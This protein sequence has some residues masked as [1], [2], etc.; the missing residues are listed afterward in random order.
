VEHHLAAARAG[1]VGRQVAEQDRPVQHGAQEPKGDRMLGQIDEDGSAAQ[2][3]PDALIGVV[4]FIVEQELVLASACS[5][6]G[7][8][9]IQ[10]GPDGR[11]GVAVENTPHGADALGPQIVLGPLDVVGW[12]RQGVHG[13]RHRSDR[14]GQ[15]NPSTN[16]RKPLVLF[17]RLPMTA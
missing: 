6:A 9:T 5:I 16:T 15:P 12:N 7:G 3:V 10:V 8:R 1:D 14:P 2:H 4:V 17:S 13:G 11:E